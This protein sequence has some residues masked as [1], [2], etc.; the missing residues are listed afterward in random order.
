MKVKID[1]K[2]KFNVITVEETQLS[3]NMTEELNR[4]LLLYLKN[5]IRN[6]VINLKQVT[7]VDKNCAD[8]I[9]NVHQTYY[10][11]NASFVL[12]EIQKPVEKFFD[13]IE[14]LE[15]LNV[16][17]TESEAGDIVQMEEIEREF[18]IPNP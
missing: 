8:M 18:D 2:E 10:E 3:A 15:I 9:L 6:V 17:P 7:E 16:T 14:L 11:N 4:M 1:T 12:C 5:E 13:N